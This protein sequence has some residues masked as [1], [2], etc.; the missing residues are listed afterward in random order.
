MNKAITD[1]LVFMPPAF[2]LG[3]T[4]W[5]SEDG[6]PGS[7]TWDGAG[8]ATLVPADADFAGALEI[9]KN[10]SITRLRYMGQTPVLP[11]CY[12]QVTA[13]IKAVSGNL[14]SVRIA[15][16]AGDVADANVP[17]V[18][19]T[20][21]SVA[22]T[23]Y[24]EVVEV[25]AIIGTGNRGGVDMPWGL[26]AVYGHFGLDLTGANGG[27]IRIDDIEIED[28]TSAFLRDSMDWVDVRDY[29]ALGDGILDCHAAFVAAD[30]DANGRDILVP[31]GTY[32]IG[33]NITLQNQPRFEGQVSMADSAQFLLRRSY[34]LD[35]YIKA[36][37]D[38]VTGFKK[39]FQ[40]LLNFTDHDAL[41]MNGR[42]LELDQPLDLFA[43]VGNK[44]TFEVR[45]VLRNGQFNLQAD[46]AW[47]DAVATSPASY[48]SSNPTQLSTVS[49]IANIAVGARVSGTGVGREVFVRAV[50]IGAQTLTLSQPLYGAASS[51]SYTFTRHQYVLD[52][53]GFAKLSQ[54]QVSDV[55]FLLNGIGSGILLCPDGQT[56]HVKD[57]HF[58]KPRDRGIS[59]HGIGCQDLQIDRCHFTSNESP[60]AST[61][62]TT[63]AF[64]VNA[65]DAKIRDNRFQHFAHTGV[66][67]GNGN[68]FVGNHLFQGDDTPDGPRQAGLIFTYPNVNSVITGNYIDN[69]S[70]EW[71]NEHDAMPD[72]SSEFSFGG[73]TVTGNIFTAIDVASWFSWLVIKPYGSGHFIHGL[74]VT[75]NTFKAIQGN[76]ARVDKLDTEYADL[77]HGSCRNLV[78]SGNTFNGVDQL[79]INPVTLT[80]SQNSVAQNWTLGVSGYLPFNGWARTVDSVIAKGAITNAGGARVNGMPWFTANYGSNNDQVQLSWEEPCQGTVL[81]TARSDNP[82]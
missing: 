75:G 56:F 43:I 79:T 17:G 67:K 40:A 73:L 16:W 48:S 45:R 81:V 36:F 24:G 63:I 51:Q 78:F 37:G 26:A 6:T 76:I 27:V 46:S 69:A 14:P 13:R 55:E 49:N 62:R 80:F 18:V 19:Q 61:A 71:T 15:A 29:G 35:T 39:A 4:Q 23:T 38:E 30:N 28:I 11:G 1:G 60:V 77:E 31:A 47:D 44:S 41:D 10:D 66:L 72:F 68:I 3:L 12:L 53:S 9:Q 64:N 7:A 5:S 42:R 57:C 74:S 59:S 8:N 22:L 34:D 54:F 20:G 21:P 58:K 70:I 32:L 52:F 50:N 33:A 82:V 2:A 65:N 25:R